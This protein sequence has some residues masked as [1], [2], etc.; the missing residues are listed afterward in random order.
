MTDT[1]REAFEMFFSAAKEQ[2]DGDTYRDVHA[3]IWE[4]WQARGEWNASAIPAFGVGAPK[5]GYLQTCQEGGDLCRAGQRD[6]VTCPE[7]SCDIDDGLRPKDVQP[8]AP[9]PLTDEQIDALQALVSMCEVH[10]D[11]SNG[12][13][14]PTGTVDEGVVRAGEII[15]AARAALAA[16]EAPPASGSPLAICCDGKS[17]LAE[18]CC[19][20]PIPRPAFGV[21]DENGC[22]ACVTCG[23][24]VE[25]GAVATV[26]PLVGWRFRVDLNS[27]WT[28]C[29]LPGPR[30]DF[31][32]EWEYVRSASQSTFWKDC[33][34]A[35]A[36]LVAFNAYSQWRDG[37]HHEQDY[38]GV[39]FGC[40][41]GNTDGVLAAGEL[42]VDV[43]DAL[44]RLSEVADTPEQ[45]LAQFKRNKE[46]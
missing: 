21:S 34:D 27:A 25:T 15:R 43:D 41:R 28:L 5:P 19:G 17:E 12:V 4:G 18:D 37:N 2:R 44:T 10:G 9:E 46:Q 40:I 45:A 20:R 24:P 31:A 39:R 33:A 32:F 11:F 26:Q 13:T 29:E 22:L 1:E 14:D 7:E 8:P 16:Q 38:V 6:G 35:G 3:D 30:E 23:Q 42:Y 36:V